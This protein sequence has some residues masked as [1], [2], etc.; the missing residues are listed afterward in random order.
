[1]RESRERCCDAIAAA[2]GCTPDALPGAVVRAV[3]LHG[4]ES[5]RIALASEERGVPTRV[6][7]RR[8][9]R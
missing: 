2:L 1:M 3:L 8:K 5:Y 4:H 9:A 6:E 7:R